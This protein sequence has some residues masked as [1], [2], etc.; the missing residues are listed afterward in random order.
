VLCSP[1]MSKAWPGAPAVVFLVF[2]APGCGSSTSAALDASSSP[3]VGCTF[4]ACENG[5]SITLQSPTGGWPAGAYAF[6]VDAD[7][8]SSTCSLQIPAAP[9][10]T[11]VLQGSC[12]APG[13]SLSFQAVTQCMMID[14]G[15]AGVSGGECGPV[16][17]QFYMILAIP[18][19]P[20][21]VSVAITRGGVQLA[22][23]SLSLSYKSFYP[24]GASCGG[25]CQQASAVLTVPAQGPD[26]GGS[27]DS[28]PSSAVGDGGMVVLSVAGLDSSCQANS[29]CVL[30][31]TG[32]WNATDPCCGHACPSA[33]ISASAQSQYSASAMQ[34]LLQC[35]PP[36]AS[37]CGTDCAALSAYCAAGMCA[38][39]MGTSCTGDGG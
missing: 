32:E 23:D 35:M 18:G 27:G 5:A 6:D 22:S 3:V 34:T 20:Q 19:L 12:A 15:V 24:N 4:G 31:A 2:G 1:G 26:G 8:T 9:S 39:C 10:G 30:V 25:A 11:S 38:V 33:A 37:A 28:G 16:P 7:G 36:G 13:T 17:G 29:D 21:D 14:A